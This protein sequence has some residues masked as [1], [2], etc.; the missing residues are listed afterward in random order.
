LFDN[1]R[2]RSGKQSYNY[3]DNQEWRSGITSKNST[4][5]RDS[6]RLSTLP[7][8]AEFLGWRGFSQLDRRLVAALCAMIKTTFR[9]VN[10]A[11]DV[12]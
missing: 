6:F 10:D 2:A 9:D 7:V 5:T 3:T 8:L 12:R 4:P 1:R 11:I